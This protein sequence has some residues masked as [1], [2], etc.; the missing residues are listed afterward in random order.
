MRAIP[1]GL[2]TSITPIAVAIIAMSC[3]EISNGSPRREADLL[4]AAV[5]SCGVHAGRPPSRTSPIRNKAVIYEH[6]VHNL[7][8][9]HDYHRRPIPKHLGARIGITSV[10]HTWGSAQRQL[11]TFPTP[12]PTPNP[13]KRPPALSVPHTPRF[14]CLGAFSDAGPVRSVG[15][16]SASRHPKNL[17]ISGSHSIP[18]RYRRRM[19]TACSRLSTPRNRAVWGLGCRSAGR[20]SKRITDNCGRAQTCPAAPH[21]NSPCLPIQT[22][23]R[24]WCLGAARG[25][26]G[27]AESDCIG[28]LPLFQS[29]F[30]K[31]AAPPSSH[32]P[33]S[34]DKECKATAAP[35]R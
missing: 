28:R 4:P 24:D 2:V 12:T 7:G 10:L 20:L 15:R 33:A 17:H 11:N 19:L 27:P 14:S 18:R 9:D 25:V 30:D 13:H 6:P 21:L 1:R 5:L 26:S 3:S 8:R 34:G 16:V 31:G 32:G 29:P 23:H 35:I 22:L